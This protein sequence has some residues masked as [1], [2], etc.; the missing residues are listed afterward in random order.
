[1][2]RT[3]KVMAANKSA[4][5]PSAKPSKSSRQRRRSV[6][7]VGG[8]LLVAGIMLVAWFP[9]SAILSQRQALNA[10]T[11]QLSNMKAQDK[12]LLHQQS[13]LTSPDEITRL[14][15][16]EYQLVQPGQRLVQVLPP[17]GTPTQAGAGQAPFP[18]DPGLTKPIAPSAIA[19]LPSTTTTTIPPM[20]PMKEQTA[21][22]TTTSTH[23]DLWQRIVSTLD[24]WHK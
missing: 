18:G 2:A 13:T 17:S 23:K 10:T 9:A 5:K 3:K 15:R 21:P 12:A 1:M 14:A 6:V 7:L 22:T 4:T 11:A 16:E 20:A 8:A 24:F 19:L